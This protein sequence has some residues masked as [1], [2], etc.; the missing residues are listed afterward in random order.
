MLS[1]QKLHVAKNFE[2]QSLAF[3]P[4]KIPT[5]E[6]KDQQITGCERAALLCPHYAIFVSSIQ[7]HSCYVSGTVVYFKIGLN[8]ILDL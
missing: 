8:F 4:F 5:V 1:G 7:L 3:I 2:F 6:K